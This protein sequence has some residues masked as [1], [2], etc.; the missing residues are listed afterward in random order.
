MYDFKKIV[1]GY[2]PTR[3]D[4]FPAP[5]PAIAQR[6]PIRKRVEEILERC[7]NVT[8]VDIDWLN[9]EKLLVERADVDRIVKR[10][11]DAGVDALFVP[12]TNFGQEET[13]AKLAKALGKPVLLWGPRDPMPPENYKNRQ[14]DSQC[15]LFAT[16]RAFLRYGVPF[17]YIENCWLEDEALEKGINHFLRVASVVKAFTNLRIGQF[18]L[19][20]WQFLSVKVNES[21]LLEKF[22]IEV[23]PFN[24][25]QILDQITAAKKEKGKQIAEI[26]AEIKS[27]N[28]CSAMT[29]EQLET[30]AAIE[31]AFMELSEKYDLRAFA[32]ECWNV[33]PEM[34]GVQ[35]CYTYGDLTERGLPVAC[36]CD[37]HGA[38]TSVL[39]TAAARGET[40]NF[41]ADIT[42]RHPENDNAELLWHCGPFPRSLAKEDSAPAVVCGHGQYELRHGD[43]TVTRF[44][45]DRGNYKLF[46]GEA[47]GVDGPSTDGNYVWIET[48]DWVKWEKKFIYGPYIHHASG[49]HGKY[50][51]VF[52]EACKYIGVEFD[53]VD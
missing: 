51:E 47:R 31:V 36:E 11:R 16:S 23:I 42:I 45:G 53:T 5:G 2:A 3:R 22:G 20:P 24:T 26:V 4:T 50:R 18:S 40:P 43:I 49:I 33:L 6:D 12:H 35:P 41:L 37:I 44:D 19:R 17:T 30:M 9:E 14:T 13:V 1:L 25:K 27:R 21:E 39:N 34:L 46:S 10:F 38:I 28:D 32:G 15:G 8:L 7:G 48:N 29:E 52:R